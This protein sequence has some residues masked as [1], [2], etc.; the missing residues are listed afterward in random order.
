MRK[1]NKNKNAKLISHNK[2]GLAEMGRPSFDSDKNNTKELYM[3]LLHSI[4]GLNNLD[5]TAFSKDIILNLVEDLINKNELIN[6]EY[7]NKYIQAIYENN[8]IYNLFENTIK[9]KELQ[10]QNDLIELEQELSKEYETISN[11]LLKFQQDAI[12]RYKIEENNFLPKT[13]FLTT[14]KKI[15][16]DEYIKIITEINQKRI[17]S[18]QEYVLSA[19]DITSINEQQQLKFKHS[20]ES[21]VEKNEYDQKMFNL[22]AEEKILELSKLLEAEEA[23][24]KQIIQVKERI[25]VQNTIEVNDLITRLGEEY[26]NRLKYAYI[27][28]EIK[29]NKLLDEMSE[30]NQTYN[31]IESQ[32]LEEFKTLLQQNDNEIEELR[33]KH[34]QFEANYLQQLRDIKKDFNSRLQKEVNLINKEI[35]LATKKYTS[36]LKKEDR[37]IVK[38]L[39]AKKKTHIK[40]ENKLKHEKI[41]AVK[42]EYYIQEL[43]YI[44]QFERLRTKKSQCEAIKSS[45]IKNINYERIYHHE[46]INSEIRLNSNEKESFSTTDH[47]EEIKEIYDNRLKCSLENEALHYEINENELIALKYKEQIKVEQDKILAEKEYHLMLSNADLVYQQESINNRINFFNVKSM[48]EIQR[49]NIINEFE[50][51]FANEKMN[52]EQIKNIFYNNCDNIQYQL[53]K[54]E[55]DLK[56]KLIDAEVKLEQD[57]SEVEKQYKKALNTHKKNLLINLKTYDENISHIKL[58]ED[59]FEIEKTMIND[60]YAAYINS[61]KNIIDFEDF[62]HSNIQTLSES[63]FNENKKQLLITLEYIR[64]IK[65]RLVD[66]YYNHETTI[67]KTRLNFEADIKFKKQFENAKKEYL[68]FVNFSKNRSDKTVQTLASY[69]ETLTSSLNVSNKTKKEITNLQINL[70]K[71]FKKKK[72]IELIKKEIEHKKENLALLK[73]QIKANKKNIKKMKILSQKQEKERKHRELKYRTR[74]HKIEKQQLYEAKIYTKQLS[75]FE[76]QYGKIKSEVIRCGQFLSATK[77]TYETAPM[78]STYVVS[79]NNLVLATSKHYFEIHNTKLNESLSEQYYY[80]RDLYSKNYERNLKEIKRSVKLSDKEYAT[81]ILATKNNHKSNVETLERQ[82]IYAK[83][84]LLIEL[85]KLNTSHLQNLAKYN[86]TISKIESKKTYELACHDENYQMYQKKFNEKNTSIINSYLVK[87]KEI[88]DN[89]NNILI[90]IQSKYNQTKKRLKTHHLN[91][92]ALNKNNILNLENEH[93]E[94]I[95]ITS[96][97]IKKINQRDRENRQ[98]HEEIKKISFKLYLQNQRNTRKEFASQLKEIERKCQKRI[99][100]LQKEFKKKF[101]NQKD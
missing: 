36:S 79:I 71:A 68:E 7:T 8:E 75:L 32:V 84:K 98:R 41:K 26:A 12:S 82:T 65:L 78:A 88:K 99:N 5:S 53:F 60:A 20:I 87:I 39:V 13:K 97:K 96:L 61:L 16:K 83:N 72:E 59:R 28:Y 50:K 40:N 51:I 10:Y 14:N 25:I 101:K 3:M 90:N 23:K 91:N 45:A 76:K 63:S 85:K 94:N 1:V 38:S 58:Y 49:A 33:L 15:N 19:N 31:I 77:Y 27:P 47:Y 18:N 42:Q 6:E 35:A 100:N 69:Q 22:E 34:R 56:Y 81:N 70:L 9:T 17:E 43:I 37:E 80:Q 64:K 55:T 89:Y 30:N 62:I 24:T 67:I 11:N 57:L 93:K 54:I 21:A 48:L 52:F 66:E 29:N 95:K 86:N 92:I 44:E 73:R 2:T 46:R 4:K 74:F